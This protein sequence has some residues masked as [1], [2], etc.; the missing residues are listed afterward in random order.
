MKREFKVG[1]RVSVE[2]H[3]IQRSAWKATLYSRFKAKVIR[4]PSQHTPSI[5]VEFD[6]PH[7]NSKGPYEVFPS[8]C[9][10]LKPKPVKKEARRVWTTERSMSD[11]D[12]GRMS[13]FWNHQP[14]L[15]DEVEF[16]EVLPG[17]V[18][19][20]RETLAKAWDKHV[21]FG[22]LNVNEAA[23]SFVF[24]SLAKALGLPEVKP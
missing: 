11:I 7:G 21:A 1:D 6:L 9:R 17:D 14:A 4:G 13:L 3:L 8:Q 12:K 16:R 19:V 5:Y 2:G 23:R 24:K 15:N 18:V 22:D 10:R 20:T